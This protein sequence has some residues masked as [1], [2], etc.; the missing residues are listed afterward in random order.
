M[1]LR[2]DT[3][4]LD[5]VVV[6]GY[7]KVKKSDLVG[8]VS[9]VDV[10]E[11]TAI[12]TT[13]VSEMIRGRAAGV[14]VNLNDA[15]PG[16]NS[17]IVIRGKVSLEGN[18]P[19]IVVDGVFYDDINN[20]AP[21]DIV[22]IEVLKDASSQAIYGARAAN[23]VILITT[24]RG[25]E[26]KFQ[27]NY[28]GYVTNQMLTKNFDIFTG[29]EYAQV[30]REAFRTENNGEYLDDATIFEPFEQEAIENGNF[31][32]WEDL[33]IR[34]ETII[35]HTISASGGGEKT[36]VYTSLNYFEQEGII[37][38]S[39][40]KRGTFRVNLDQEITDKLSFEANINI[41][42]NEQNIETGN[43]DVINISPLA[44]PFDDNGELIREPLG[45]GRLTV[46]PLWNIR[47]SDND[48]F[49]NLRDLNLVG[50]YQIA[51]NFSYKLNAFSR[52]RNT[53]Q[54]IYRSTNHPAGDG[55][56][57]GL[58]TLENRNYEEFLVEN[59]IDYSP[60]LGDRHSL[61]LT[62]VQAV[63]QRRTEENSIT[64]SGFAND[65]LGYNGKA[66]LIRGTTRDVSKRRLVSF[67]GRA[68]YSYLDRYL[69][70][71]TLRGDGS[72]VFAENEKYGYFPAAAF[73]WKIH[74][75]EFLKGSDVFQELKLRLSYGATGNE[76]IDPSE[77]L[78]VA[79][80]LP[81]V[82]SGNTVGGFAPL[83]RLPNPNLKWETTTTFNTALDFRLFNNLINGT[84]E[85]YQASTTDFLLDRILSGTSG[86]NV[87]RF[88]IGEVENK[89]FE[90]TINTNIITKPDLQ[91][92]A[93][94]I[95]STNDN[96]IVSLAGERD[97]EGNLIDFESQGLFIGESIDNI[98][99]FVFDGIFQEDDDI[100]NSAQPEALPG[101]P[102]VRDLNDD[103]EITDEDRV[104]IDQNPDWYGSLNTTLKYKGFDLFADFYFVEGATRINPY[105]AD[106][107]LGASYQGGA[108]SIAVDYYL[109]EDPSNR[110]IRPT[111]ATP[112]F[113]RALAVEDASYQRLRTLTL[114]YNLPRETLD[115]IGLEQFRIY[116]TGTNLI[117][118]TD[119]RSYSPE[120]NP[121][122]FPDAMGITLGVQI[123][124]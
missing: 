59:I 3:S 82:F 53:R 80:D 63:N 9:S 24:K 94:V 47:E 43:L 41:Q 86:F 51:P 76:G 91:W 85:Y 38:T 114:G 113:L 44:K 12:P 107:N 93:G 5:E 122:Q 78:G 30:R 21:D 35:S 18:D 16:G 55:D 81:Y 101:E 1:Q 29:P 121:G 117:T 56:I 120:N 6:V 119:F 95:W 17:N 90:A 71:L 123:G 50:L 99:Q 116:A 103:G 40:F 10:E 48:V 64:K 52:A 26:G 14:Q 108:N 73:A 74:D 87:T 75:E 4:K 112:S 62:A 102:K 88:N 84:M 66:D 7:G 92:S 45:Q 83:N 15:R 111:T 67:M 106:G 54:G 25:R 109:P 97:Q 89:G 23:G 98:D 124:I 22:S 100:A 72:S 2:P 37:P 105:F 65:N 57:R 61:D 104:V 28:H 79:D 110:Y 118:I 31:V 19:L 34:D 33:V 27:V 77:S 60:K 70:T 36:K 58:A 20:V 46:N 115:K 96:K 13:N 11:A 69:L 39:G 49:A 32:D 8:S 42:K 68:V